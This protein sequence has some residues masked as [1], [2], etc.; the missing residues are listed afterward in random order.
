[1]SRILGLRWRHGLIAVLI[2]IDL[3]GPT[4]LPLEQEQRY[5]Y[6]ALPGSDNADADRSVRILV[7][8]ITHAHHFVRRVALW[9][10]A[11][12]DD[13]EVVRGAA[14]SARTGRF[15]ISTTR[16]VAAIDLRTDKIVWERSYEGHCCDRLAVSPD[17]QTIYAPAFG[18]PKWYVIGAAT[19]ELRATIGAMGWPRDTIYSGDGKRVYL[20]AW[21]SL[22]LSLADTATH[23]IT[24]T[25]GPFSAFLCPFTVN[26]KETLAFANVDGLVGFEVADLQTGQILDSVAVEGYDKDAAAQYECPSHGIALTHDQRQLWVAD[27][28][29]NR[30]HVFDATVYPP[31]AVG[32]IELS[33]QPRWITVSSDDRF[34]YPSTGE[35][36]DV[37]TKRI[38]GSLRDPSGARALSENLVE[39]DGPND[40]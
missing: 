1:M 30:L 5:L 18:S 11:R 36:I 22:V 35:I 15:Y 10:A 19:G 2:P 16:R 20:S 32:A 40:H 23:R 3:I 39:I 33:G 38:V 12:G 6:V 24:R 29:R 28:V 14:A 27:G 34:A 17:G 26:A 7:F 25:A 4:R 37:A 13:A 31:T 9:P 21:E 8:D